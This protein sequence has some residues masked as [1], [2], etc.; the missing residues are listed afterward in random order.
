MKALAS[1]IDSQ[2]Q[3]GFISGAFPSEWQMYGD[4]IYEQENFQVALARFDNLGVSRTSLPLANRPDSKQVI[5]L[6]DNLKH[7]VPSLGSLSLHDYK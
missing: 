5:Q 2:Y 3:K 6:L 7:A 1:S 4:W